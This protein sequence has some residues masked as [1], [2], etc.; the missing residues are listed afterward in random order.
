MNRRNFLTAAVA[1]TAALTVAPVATALTVQDRIPVPTPPVMDETTLNT[2]WGTYGKH[3][4]THCNGACPQHQLRWV[5]LV[6]CE[7][8]HLL[9]ILAT[10][11]QIA[12][13]QYPRIIKVILMN[14]GFNESQIADAVEAARS[15]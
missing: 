15:V 9:A 3:G 4:L 6:D 11:Y 8:S 1:T 10:Q 5:R 13:T 12:Y 7:T 14:R 2:M